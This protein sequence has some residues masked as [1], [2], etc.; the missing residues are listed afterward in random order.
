[1]E[2]IKYL[3]TNWDFW[4]WTVTLAFFV[5]ATKRFLAAD[6][7]Y[8]EMVFNEKPWERQMRLDEERYWAV[9]SPIHADR[10]SMF[11][12]SL[13]FFGLVSWGV[14]S[15]VLEFLGYISA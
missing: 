11:F 1:M 13:I 12:L 14:G 4:T 2:L 10:C 5:L 9:S 7:V 3:A 6:E 15:D 8:N